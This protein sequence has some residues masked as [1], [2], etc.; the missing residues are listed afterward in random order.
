MF[1][2]TERCGSSA[3]RR[4]AGTS[5]TPA[6]IASYGCRAF[7]DAAADADLAARGRPLPGEHGEELVLPLAFERG[8]AEDLAGSEREGDALDEADATGRRPRAPAAAS[9]RRTRRGARPR[10]ARPRPT[11]ACAASAPS[12]YSTIV[13]SPPSSGTIV[14]T[15][16]PSRRIVARSQA[17]ITSLRRCVMKSTERPR[18]RDARITVNTRSARSDG[19]AAVISSSRSSCG[20]RA[21]ARARSI[22]RSIGSGTSR[23]QLAEV[24]VEVERAQLAPHGLGIRAGQAHVLGDRQV[25]H[26]RGILE[27]GREP[28]PRR[29][30]RRADADRLAVDRDGA[31][32][33]AITPVSTLTS[34]LFPAPFAPSS[35]CTSPGSTTRSA[36]RSATRGRSSSPGRV[37]REVGRSRSW[38]ENAGEGARALSRGSIA[39][40]GP[41]QAVSCCGRVGRPRL[42]LQP[43]AVGRRTASASSS[44]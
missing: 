12:M 34:V 18:S 31:A 33:A 5:T 41:L 42:D 17:A 21:S 20:S 11:A 1:S 8:D 9:A 16:P 29:L 38:R 28:D 27:D 22:I 13:S 36:E 40:Y 35:A 23:D 26:E 24:D 39:R 25:G 4:S 37:L 15:A 6:R 3:C 44:P 14:A 2:R 43:C 32:V 30:R 10:P 7:S 19:S